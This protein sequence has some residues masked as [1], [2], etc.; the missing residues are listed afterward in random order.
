MDFAN[1]YDI[2]MVTVLPCFVF[3][4]FITPFRPS[5]VG[6][7]MALFTIK[8]HALNFIMRMCLFYEVSWSLLIAQ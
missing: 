3:G 5:S 6:L 8:Y 7:G 2:D 1:E 4:P